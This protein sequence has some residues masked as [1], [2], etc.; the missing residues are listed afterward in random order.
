[1]H[2]YQNIV[3]L[4][5]IFITICYNVKYPGAPV[6][7]GSPHYPGHKGGKVVMANQQ[8]NKASI[9]H[10][11]QVKLKLSVLTGLMEADME[12]HWHE[13]ARLKDRMKDAGFEHWVT[14]CLLDL[15]EMYFN[16]FCHILPEL[17]SLLERE[18]A[19]TG[20]SPPPMPAPST[21]H[22]QRAFE[23]QKK[24]FSSAGEGWSYRMLEEHVLQGYTKIR[25]V[26]EKEG[27]FAT[28]RHTAGKM[29]KLGFPLHTIVAITGHT[30][31]SG[32]ADLSRRGNEDTGDDEIV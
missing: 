24:L 19:M 7:T 17:H 18:K 20:Q 15:E 16:Y 28:R 12:G 6:L 14:F 31:E 3:F 13:R 8:K 30:P 26:S 25:K 22:R 32:P 21:K 23:L 27:A 4:F 1:V 5:T 11:K 29:K 2:L 9:E 10:R